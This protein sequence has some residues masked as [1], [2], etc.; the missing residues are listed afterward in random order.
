[1]EGKMRYSSKS[2]TTDKLSYV[3]SRQYEPLGTERYIAFL[4][5]VILYT[6]VFAKALQK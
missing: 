2:T 5:F 4:I 1:M 6:H 3:S